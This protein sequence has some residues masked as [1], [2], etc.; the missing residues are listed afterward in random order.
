MR[1][2]FRLLMA[3]LAALLVLAAGCGT[4]AVDNAGE[5]PRGPFR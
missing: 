5:T 2:R 1:Y 4:D 3:M